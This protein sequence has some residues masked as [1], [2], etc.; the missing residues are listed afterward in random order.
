MTFYEIQ[1][2]RQ[3][4][5]V[6]LPTVLTSFALFFTSMRIY[7]RRLQKTRILADDYLCI[8]ACVSLTN[9][10][11]NRNL[12]HCLRLSKHETCLH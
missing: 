9:Q 4:L 5:L 12:C 1:N 3:R 7:A 10:T 8:A 2:G 11:K 6:A